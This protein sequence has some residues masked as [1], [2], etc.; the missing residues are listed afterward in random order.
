MIILCIDDGAS[1]LSLSLAV[2]VTSN[3]LKP[4]ET[5]TIGPVQFEQTRQLHVTIAL[6][7]IK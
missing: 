6:T 3:Y 2:V 1:I 7:I 4:I 5:F